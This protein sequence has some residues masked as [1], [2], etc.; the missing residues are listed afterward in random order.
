MVDD[1]LGLLRTPFLEISGTQITALSLITAIVIVVAAR[2]VAGILSRSLERLFARRSV[3]ASV[4]FA[5]TKILRWVAVMVGALVAL[6]TIGMD[7]NAVLA[8]LAVLLVGI[9]FGLQ[10][11]AENF[12][13]GL[14]LLVERPLRIG[15]FVE[16]DDR[17]GTIEDIGLRATKLTTRDGLTYL[18]PNAELVSKRVTNYTSPSASL[19]IWVPVRV[20][21]GTDLGLAS[22]VLLQVAAREALV[23]ETPAPEV[24]HQGFG[25]SSIDLA[26]V[27]WIANADDDDEAMSALHFAISEAFASHSIEIPFPQRDLHVLPAE[28]ARERRTPRPRGTEPPELLPRR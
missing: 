26:L 6:T 8:V 16:V 19:R 2:L 14:I 1:A 20:S 25:D 15:D 21:Y 24:R 23:L 10:K 4:G 11:V 27:V 9:G 28:P 22:R 13:S 3:D 18:I 7:M 5:V 12:I 17:K